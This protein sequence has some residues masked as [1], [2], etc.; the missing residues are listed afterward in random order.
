MRK[1]ETWLT[2]LLW[3]ALALLL[4]MAAFEPA[5]AAGAAQAGLSQ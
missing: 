2:G 4:P 5:D 3:V 1:T